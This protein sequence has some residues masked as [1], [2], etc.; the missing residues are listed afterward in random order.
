MGC[1]CGVSTMIAG[2]RNGGRDLSERLTVFVTTVG[3]DVNYHD[4]LAHL[5]RQTVRFRLETIPFVGPLSSALQVMLD[6]CETPYYVQV[7]EDMLLFPHALEA[8]VENIEAAPPA[9]ALVCAGL[10]D[11]DVGHPINGVKIYRHSIVRQ[12]P[13]ENTFSCEKTQLKKIQEAGYETLLLPL[14]DRSACL[15]EHG[16]H[17]T[18]GTIFARWRRLFHKHRR[19][20]YPAWVEPW[21]ALLLERYL[22]TQE[23]LHLYALLGAVAGIVG[24]LPPDREMDF[25]EGCPDFERLVRYFPPGEAAARPSAEAPGCVEAC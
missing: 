7:D 11:C 21:P 25:R 2:N 23:P 24:D 15:G 3:D 19:C 14:R 18:P 1:G 12:F 6:R 10:W 17:Y 20:G 9:T 5:Q 8:L 13:Y 16:K 4:C 22:S